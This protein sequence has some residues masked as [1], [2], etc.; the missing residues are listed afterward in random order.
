MEKGQKTSS[1][2]DNKV[3]IKQYAGM[4]CCSKKQ[5]QHTGMLT[6]YSANGK[7]EKNMTEKCTIKLTL[8]L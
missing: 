2:L 4:D 5:K 6:T 8:K 7:P 1:I 3:G